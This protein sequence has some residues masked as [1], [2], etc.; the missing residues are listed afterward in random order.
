MTAPRRI[1]GKLGRTP[2]RGRDRI[3]L[4][5]DHKPSGYIPPDTL[6]HY[7][8][9][10]VA[11]WG[12]DGNDEVGD[13]TIA[14]GD[15]E[16]KY[17]EV[18]AGNAEASSTTDEVIGVYSAIT[19]YDPA[20]PS[21]DQ[22]AEMQAV[23]E[24]WRKTGLTLGG[25][26]H[27]ILLFA[28]I[29][30]TDL[31]LVKWTL[32]EFGMVGLGV[33]FPD[34]AMK[35]FNAGEPWT[36]VKGAQDEGGHAIAL[37]G[38]DKDYAYVLT[39]GQVQKVAWSWWKKYVEEAWGAFSTERVNAVSGTTE[40]AQTLYQLGQQ[41]QRLTDQP[42]P[43]P[44]PAPSP[45]PTPDPEPTPSP[46]PDPA[47]PVVDD[48]DQALADAVRDWAQERHFRDNRKIAEALEEWLRVKGLD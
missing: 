35:Q 32:D 46:S 13:C 30:H 7:T 38:W 44:P 22:G 6:D 39:W 40:T 1:A 19:G 37:V 34:S 4:T 47:P 41:F 45:S 26:P 24:Y 12:M 36:V 14:D 43:V 18:L 10:P 11:T 28:E 29:D 3:R 9:V 8:A 21:T 33:N 2:N 48:A 27:Q 17:V 42:N 5:S 15:H 31:D 23:R 25:Q 16:T 20:D